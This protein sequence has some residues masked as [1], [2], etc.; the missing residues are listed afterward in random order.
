MATSPCAAYRCC[1][2]LLRTSSAQRCCCPLVCRRKTA[3]TA[4]GSVMTSPSTGWSPP[5]PSKRR[6]TSGRWAIEE[7]VSRGPV[8]AHLLVRLPAAAPAAPRLCRTLSGTL[9]SAQVYKQGQEGLA[10]H[11]RDE[12]RYFDGVQGDKHRKG[13]LFGMRNLLAFE[14][15]AVNGGWS[16]AAALLGDGCAADADCSFLIAP[17]S[18]DGRAGA[19]QGGDEADDKIEIEDEIEEVEDEIE[20]IE[21]EIEEIGDEIDEIGDE[22]ESKDEAAPRRT[23]GQV[24]SG[25]AAAAAIEPEMHSQEQAYPYDAYSLSL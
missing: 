24:A 16:E 7:A 2:L 9:A 5:T 1:L 10:L 19:R 3:P 11:Q 6:F 13:E 20:E 22:I 17:D 12:H 25:N 4:S 18:R 23:G 21:D 15:Q 14:E 8:L